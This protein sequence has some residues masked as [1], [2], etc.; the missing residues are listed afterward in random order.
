MKDFRNPTPEQVAVYEDFKAK[1]AAA[2]DR[3]W[4]DIF[5]R[6]KALAENENTDS[7]GT[8]RNVVNLK[9]P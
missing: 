5:T 8:K 2:D 7:M 1:C 4:R 6:L 3:I 9:G